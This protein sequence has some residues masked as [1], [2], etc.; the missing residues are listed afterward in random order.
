MTFSRVN[1]GGWALYETLTSAQMN[2][3]DLNVSRALDGYAGGDYSPSSD[4]KVHGK[5]IGEDVESRTF[6]YPIGVLSG[7]VSTGWAWFGT[8]HTWQCTTDDPDS[9]LTFDLNR[10][11]RQNVILQRVRAYVVPGAA[12]ATKDDR[13]QLRIRYWTVGVA[14]TTA[15]ESYYPSGTLTSGQ[16]IDTN[17]GTHDGGDGAATLTDSWRGWSGLDLTGYTVYNVTDGSHGTITGNTATTVSATLSGGTD[18]DWDDGDV[19]Y[20]DR[21]IVGM[22]TTTLMV[23]AQVRPAAGFASASDL[24]A[25]EI[26]YVEGDYLMVP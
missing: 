10:F 18:N 1:V 14:G 24:Y 21:A 12:E 7:D 2:A 22:D 13:L 23:A 11:V 6:L 9:F 5:I 15:A 17:G 26:T 3:L 4:L 19:Y 16:W 8:A 20:I 25:L